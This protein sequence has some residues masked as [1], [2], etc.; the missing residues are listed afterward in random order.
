MTCFLDYMNCEILFISDATSPL[1][2]LMIVFASEVEFFSV[3][4]I[5]FSLTQYLEILSSRICAV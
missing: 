3:L 5:V 1:D 4:R 2:E